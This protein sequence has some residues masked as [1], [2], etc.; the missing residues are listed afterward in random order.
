MS[1]VIALAIVV[2]P[3][4]SLGIAVVDTVRS[5]G[6]RGGYPAVALT[7]RSYGA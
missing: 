1:L 6:R 5:A 7:Y 4:V 2:I 3:L